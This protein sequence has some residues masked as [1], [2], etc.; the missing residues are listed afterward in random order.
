MTIKTAKKLNE[1]R[2][3]ATTFDIITRDG[4]LTIVGPH[5]E[6]VFSEILDL[7]KSVYPSVLE[8][9]IIRS[10]G[11]GKYVSTDAGCAY[12]SYDKLIISGEGDLMDALRIPLQ[13]FLD[14]KNSDSLARYEAYRIACSQGVAI[15]PPE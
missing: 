4:G 14:G 6:N 7:M 15:P 5:V 8:K 12:V 3:L 1:L 2:A 9:R 11:E 10:A 13:A